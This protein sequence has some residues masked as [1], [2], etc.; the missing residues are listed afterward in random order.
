MSATTHIVLWY[1]LKAM[2][3]MLALIYLGLVFMGYASEG[4]YYQPRFH[5]SEP[6]RSG[7]RLLVWT[8]IRVFDV[9]LRIG[10]S[11]L[12]QL[13]TASAEVGLWVIDRS[14]AEV[15]RKVRSKFL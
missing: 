2:V 15:Q 11:M 5:W 4:R 3:A 13:F 9:F 1:S 7:E 14:S 12:D 6:A 10:R 8:G